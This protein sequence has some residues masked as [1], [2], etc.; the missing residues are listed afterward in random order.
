MD[1]I[2]VAVG[3]DLDR[4]N[5]GPRD[6]AGRLRPVADGAI[7]VGQVVRRLSADVGISKSGEYK[8]QTGLYAVHTSS[9]PILTMKYSARTF[10]T[11]FALC[12]SFDPIK[13]TS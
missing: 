4:R 1:H 3:R 12:I 6:S 11:F 13:P 2:D 9:R 10:P 5:R 7:T 8:H